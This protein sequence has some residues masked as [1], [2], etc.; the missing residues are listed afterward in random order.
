MTFFLH[1]DTSD[2]LTYLLR[3]LGHEYRL[4]REVLGK[5]ASDAEILALAY[6]RGWV[7]ITCNRDDYLT[8]ARTNPHSGIIVLIRRKTRVG[9]R[10]ALVQLLNR[11]GEQGIRNNINFA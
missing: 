7:V 9:E 10:A 2:N 1:N 4:V 3:E 5:E 8:L 11:A 6:E